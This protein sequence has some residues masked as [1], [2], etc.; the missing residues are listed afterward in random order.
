MKFTN[1]KTIKSDQMNKTTKQ[2]VNITNYN[3]EV[4][5][6]GM[7]ISQAIKDTKNFKNKI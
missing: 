4:K 2:K 6:I 3:I 7:C 5:T 1:N